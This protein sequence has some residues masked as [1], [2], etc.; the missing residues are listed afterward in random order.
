[1]PCSL[2]QKETKSKKTKLMNDISKYLTDRPDLI[3]VGVEPKLIIN[4]KQHPTG[5]NKTQFLKND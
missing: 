2:H 4:G 1:M 5:T 3:D